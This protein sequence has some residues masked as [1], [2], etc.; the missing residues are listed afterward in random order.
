MDVDGTMTD[1]RIYL[2]EE[3]EIFK[4][5]DVKD[6]M[7]V[8]MA[9][10][11]GIRTAIITG[12]RSKIVERR[13]MELGINEVYLGVS[14]KTV[15]FDAFI[16]KYGGENSSVAYIGDDVNDIPVMKLSG[17]SFAPSDAVSDVK[18]QVTV[19]L[20]SKGGY[21]AVRECV[22]Y[23]VQYNKDVSTAV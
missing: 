8:K 6:G 15:A 5:F 10:E 20:K 22:E 17:I 11:N 18:K 7:G 9:H 12:R 16:K 4:V 19:V 3:G 21:G 13:A 23:L 14:D 1:G 2:S